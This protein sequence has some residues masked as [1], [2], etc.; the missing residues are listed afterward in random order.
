MVNKSLNT[1]VLNICKTTEEWNNETSVISKGLLCI[2]FTT[3]GKTLAK[4]GDGIN[5]YSTL[6]YVA[7]PSIGDIE[8]VLASVVEVTE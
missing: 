2:E 3:D 8:T 4:V 1:Q 6:A 7:D 5:P